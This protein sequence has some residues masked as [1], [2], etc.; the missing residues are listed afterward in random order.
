MLGL[1]APPRATHTGAGFIPPVIPLRTIVTNNRIPT[2]K[3]ARSETAV[4]TRWQYVLAADASELRF[5]NNGWALEASGE[6]NTGNDFTIADQSIEIAGVTSPIY[7][8][9]GRSLLVTNGAVDLQ[10]DVL[11]PSAFGLSKF[12]YGTVFWI[13][14]KIT[15]ASSGLAVPYTAESLTGSGGVSGTQAAWYNPGSTTVSSTDTAGAYTSTGTTP[16]SRVTAYRPMVLGRPV[17][18]G[19]SFVTVGDS[20]AQNVNDSGTAYNVHGGGYIQRAMRSSTNTDYLPNLNMARNGSGSGAIVGSNTKTRQ[21]YKYA[22][23]GID[24]YGTNN[25]NTG[26]LRTD[27]QNIWSHMRSAG[28]DKIVRMKY[29]P[30]TTTSDSW[31]TEANQTYKSDGNWQAGA[32]ADLNNQWFDTL[33]G[34]LLDVVVPTTNAQ[35]AADGGDPWKWRVNGSPNYVSSDDTHPNNTG[36]EFVAVTLRPVLRGL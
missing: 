29:L 7:Y 13:K 36:H 4:Y 33:A 31:S 24:E 12:D 21:F 8:S 35:A 11:L 26:Q 30:R 19:K 34:T 6:A 17:T 9:G 15:L 5:S 25:M 1:S 18:D 32:A 20:I 2:G 28:I 23:Y 27:L 10:S 14:T 22:R 3:E 16:A